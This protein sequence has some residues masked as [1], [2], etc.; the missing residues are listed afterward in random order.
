MSRPVHHPHKIDLRS[1]IK[2]SS[3]LELSRDWKRQYLRLPGNDWLCDIPDEYVADRFN[4]FGLKEEFPSHFNI[5]CDVIIGRVDV[6]S[7]NAAQARKILDQLP[8]VYGLI[9]QRYI[10]S[11]GG[12]RD[13][14]CKYRNCVYGTCPRVRCSVEGSGEPLLPIGLTHKLGQRVKTFCPCCRQVYDARP[15]QTLD[16]A[17]FGPNMVH[18]F[19]DEHD[20]VKRHKMYAP[21][22]HKAFGF[23]VRNE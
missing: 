22:Q 12:L 11:Q 14:Y 20:L 21:F 5:C 1:T 4:L 10:M 13:I 18:I 2:H 8:I 23:R 6:D 7:I 19:L 17:F 16:G 3:E 9:H 15:G